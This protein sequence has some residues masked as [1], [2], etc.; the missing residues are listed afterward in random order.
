MANWNLPS[1]TD[2]YANFLSYLKAR[3]DDAMRLNDSR[4]ADASNLPDYSK[5]WNDTT[6]TIQNWLSSTVGWTSVVIGV[7]GGGTG[8]STAADA[9]T[10]LSVYSIAE[11]DVAFATDLT[12]VSGNLAADVTMVTTN[13]YYDGPTASL[14]A[15]TWLVVGSVL[16]AA[17]TSQSLDAYAKLY[18]GS[19]IYGFGVVSMGGIPGGSGYAS[20]PFSAIITLGATTSIKIA[21]KCVNATSNALIRGMLE[22]TTSRITAV[23]IG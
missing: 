16:L 5:R 10:N 2:L 13:T 17:N 4:A 22:G 3:D 7:A 8:A 19:T 1:L 20:I 18:A 9:R 11:A 12:S 15:G 14:T 21:A 6:N 23:K